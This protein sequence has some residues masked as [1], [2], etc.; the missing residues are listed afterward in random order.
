LMGYN[1]NVPA[2]LWKRRNV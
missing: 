1:R 2:S